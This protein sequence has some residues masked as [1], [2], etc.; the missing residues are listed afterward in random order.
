ML[1]LGTLPEGEA[2]AETHPLQGVYGPVVMTGPCD[3]EGNTMDLHPILGAWV[4]H[5]WEAIIVLGL[6]IEAQLN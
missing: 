2:C 3:E 1:K 4:H 6:R 5:C